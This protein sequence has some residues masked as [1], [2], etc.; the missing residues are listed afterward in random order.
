MIGPRTRSDRQFAPRRTT[1]LPGAQPAET[2]TDR[3]KS[4]AG[5]KRAPPQRPTKRIPNGIPRPAS[6]PP[7]RG[8]IQRTSRHDPSR[9]EE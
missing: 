4:G 9:I 7:G 6:L 8:M 2:P 3:L 5:T 1:A